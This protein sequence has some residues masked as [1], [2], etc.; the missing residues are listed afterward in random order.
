M[1]E[2]MAALS[3]FSL[4]LNLSTYCIDRMHEVEVYT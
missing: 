4:L 1:T 3:L 2:I